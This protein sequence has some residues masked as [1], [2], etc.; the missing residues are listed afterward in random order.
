[1]LGLTS[2]KVYKSI[3]SVNTTN[4]KFELPTDTFDEFSFE[5][6]DDLEEIFETS[7]I[8][9]NHLQHEKVV[10]RII[11]AF[12]KWLEKS[13]TDAY[14]ILLMDYARSPFRDF[15]SNFRI[16]VWFRWRW[17]SIINYL[18]YFKLP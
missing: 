1:M 4:N 12:K 10:P 7:D 11:E 3:F 18:K 8:T 17:I 15:D 14:I 2:L 13:S 9:P 16:I 6:E 5:V